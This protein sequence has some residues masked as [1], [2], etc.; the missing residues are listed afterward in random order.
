MH[1]DEERRTQGMKRRAESERR[2]VDSSPHIPNCGL[3][4]VTA[5]PPI[6][7]PQT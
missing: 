6:L 1:M 2:N 5:L 4:E 3:A 7:P